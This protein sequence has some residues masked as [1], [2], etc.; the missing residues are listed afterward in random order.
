MKTVTVAQMREL[1]RRT[2]EE[3][4][5]PGEV[6]MERAA[7]GLTCKI[8]QLAHMLGGINGPIFFLAGKGNSGGDA[9]ASAR[10]LLELNYRVEVWLAGK[11]EELKGDALLHFERM[12]VAGVPC[13]E[14]PDGK[15]WAVDPWRA[16]YDGAILVDGLLGTGTSGKPREPMA[17]AIR[18]I[19]QQASRAFVVSIDI[20]S[21][22]SGDTGEVLGDVVEADITVT[23]GCPKAG[24]IKATAI[25]YV[26]VLE[27]IDIGIP[28]PYVE[29]IV[30]PEGS[31]L[32]ARTDLEE[33]FPKRPRV[34]HKGNYGRVL[35]IGGAKGYAGAIT[36][37][38]KAAGRSGVGLVTV[39]VP[40][41][42]APVVAGSALEAMVTGV[43]ET[44]DGSLSDTF[45]E[46][47]GGRLGVFDAV[48]VGPGLTRHKR[49][50]ALVQQLLQQCKVP[51]VVD[52]DAISV[53]ETESSCFAGASCPLV[54]T[55]HPGELA[56]LM[57]VETEHIQAD[58]EK[59]ATEASMA[60]QGAIVLK[61][62]GTVIAAPGKPVCVNL[63]GNPGMA[64]GGSGDV[65]AGILVGFIGQGLDPFNAARAAVYIH[66]RAGDRAAWQKSQ[67]GIVAG[68]LI[69]ELLYALPELSSR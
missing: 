28:E 36:M 30:E 22:L 33:F 55:P 17:S 3:Y 25:P 6:L 37:A 43:E 44:E 24:M 2:I 13:R 49:S 31:E 9:F 58:R 66:G 19:N 11:A 65:L 53:F 68:D 67:A 59:A 41:S 60:V 57:G 42:I 35:L 56:R 20:P 46:A 62:A 34:S 52:A 12:N 39:V 50:R 10:Q 32:V 1:D 63:T 16:E 5:T 21:G 48:L 29:E 7:S 64:T 4:G 14:L 27:V 54:L 40:E 61:G 15:Q 8:S 69:E 45:L 47:W 23:M 18:W 38:A 26:G 51:L